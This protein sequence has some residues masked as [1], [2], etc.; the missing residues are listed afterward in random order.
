[1]ELVRCWEEEGVTIPEPYHRNIKFIFAPDKLG[2]PELGFQIV[3]L[4]PGGR[5]DYHKH[6]RPELIYVVDGQGRTVC[7]GVEHDVETDVVLWVRAEEV[8]Q[9]INTG[10]Q[11]MKLAT[12]FVPGYDSNELSTSRL[13]V[14]ED[15][16]DEKR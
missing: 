13:K 12:V 1:M 15:A 8:H 2:V 3:T 4:S 11:N 14:A 6:D 10:E 5:T 7:D 9:M 16:R